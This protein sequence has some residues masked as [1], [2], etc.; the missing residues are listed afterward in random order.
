MVIFF[1]STDPVAERISP[2]SARRYQKVN[3]QEVTPGW[4]GIYRAVEWADIRVHES[5]MLICRTHVAVCVSLVEA[6]DIPASSEVVQG[7]LPDPL[8]FS[9][10]L[11]RW[12]T[13][14]HDQFQ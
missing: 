8:E 11:I 2:Y 1:V 7:I 12:E 5:L 4:L 9:V 14:R 6:D 13:T 3:W 10:E